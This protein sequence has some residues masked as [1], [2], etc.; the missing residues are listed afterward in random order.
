MPSPKVIALV[1]NW[2]LVDDTLH[3]VES[4]RQSD[5]AHL[6]VV[7]V[8]NGSDP[9]L[10]QQLCSGLPNGTTLLRSEENL[11]FAAGNNLGLR[12]ALDHGADYVF[13][14]NN[15]TLVD[16]VMVSQVVAAAQANPQA[17]LLGPIIYY[18]SAP[19]SVW[20]AGYRFSHGI[21][22]LR[23]GLRL[24][25][26]LKPVEDVDF[27]SGCGVLMSRALLEKVG[28]FATDYFM[29]YE[30]LDLCFRARE[31]GFRILCVTGARMWHAVSTSTG[32]TDSPLKQYYQVKSS[33][34]FYR[35]HFSGV[36]LWLNVGLRYAHAGY[37]L[38]G[39]LLRGR[40]KWAAVKLFLQGSREGFQPLSMASRTATPSTGQNI[41]FLATER[42][43]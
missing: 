39:A 1:L 43:D 20:F 24:S 8:D 36:K 13:V 3:C 41:E 33:L 21:Y 32:G 6:E 40:L 30:D 35:R 19:D 31:A 28:L 2:N 18:M 14:I 26:P 9:P 22:V 16:P 15:D 27:V 29:Y 34:I 25:A 5:Y 42:R 17:G 10:F 37:T 23:R 7:V 11:G 38:I 4:L 12:Y